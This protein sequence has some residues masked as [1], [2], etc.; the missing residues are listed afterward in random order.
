MGR[1]FAPASGGFTIAS[2]HGADKAGTYDLVVGGDY[3]NLYNVVGGGDVFVGGNMNWTG[4]TLPNNAYV[5]GNVTN[6]GYGSVGG[7]IYYAGTYS[8]VGTLNAAKVKTPTAT[9]IDFLGAQTAL[10]TLSA[11]LAAQASNTKVS[12]AYNTY[13][14]TGTDSTLNVFN[15]TDT[16]YNGSTIN[17]SA[18]AGSTVVVNVAGAADSFNAGSI[19][20]TGV[21]ASNVIFNFGAAKTLALASIAFNGTILAPYAAVNGTW[22]QVNGQVIANSITGTTELHDVLFTGN[23]SSVTA[24]TTVTSSQSAAAPEPATWLLVLAV[25][26]S[27]LLGSAKQRAAVLAKVGVRSN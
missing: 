25:G 18:P 15:L 9:P 7:T 24:S 16:S 21:T 20:F 13:T 5:N 1:N 3:T 14:M 11:N 26:L 4:P 12:V 23:L 10:Q 22:G 17:I 8:S 19:N 2:L 27:V 6:S